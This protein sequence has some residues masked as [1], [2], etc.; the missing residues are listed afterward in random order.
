MIS[1]Y[2]ELAPAKL[3]LYLHI[4]GRRDDGYHLLDSQ[5]VFSEFG[6]VLRVEAGEELTLS[7]VGEGVEALAADTQD[8]LVYRAAKRLQVA[9]GIDQGAHITLEKHIP[10]GAGLG[11]GSADA[12]AALRLLRRFW[13]IRIGD[14][15]LHA[16]AQSLGADVPACLRS[17]PLF[18]AG[19]GDELT[20]MH[21]P[22]SYA[23][24]LVNPN[25]SLL[26][27]EVYAAY[28]HPYDAHYVRPY[29]DADDQAGWREML[30]RSRNDLE[31]AAI[32]LMP[33]IEAVL[34]SI[35]AQPGCY[36]SR[37]CGSGATCFGLFDTDDQVQNACQS[38]MKTHPDW[39]VQVTK[40]M[41]G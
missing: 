18:M 26:T 29:Y 27:K 4:I 10:V 14:E 1:A 30:V 21:F 6:D 7:I 19:I 17:T 34:T 37:L 40:T 22:A 11:G 20:G 32:S 23:V 25:R 12:A 31:L 33:E 16:M 39:W 2:V 13:N 5:V 8:N 41:V 9:A 15:Q 28:R 36:F 35:A 24:L 38:I 3:N